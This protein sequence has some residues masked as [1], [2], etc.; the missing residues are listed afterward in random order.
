MPSTALKISKHLLAFALLFCFYTVSAQVKYDAITFRI[1][2]LA[3]I[4]LPKSALKE[5]DKLD[6]L[7]RKDNN[8]PQQIRAVIYRMTF[9]SYI[10]ENALTAIVS[11]LRA[12]ISRAN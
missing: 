11:R 5:V 7:A 8:A 3:N 2:S 4:G 12:D 9:Q 10:E 1:D 6:D